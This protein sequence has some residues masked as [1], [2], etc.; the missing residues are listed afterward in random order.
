MQWMDGEA[1]FIQ[2][3]FMIPG[4]FPYVSPVCLCVT[5]MNNDNLMLCEWM[6]DWIDLYLYQTR[7]LA[8]HPSPY[9]SFCIQAG[10]PRGACPDLIQLR[11]EW[12]LVN[13]R[14]DSLSS[15]QGRAFYATLLIPDNDLKI[16]QSINQS[17]QTR[18]HS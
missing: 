2:T 11:Y 8:Y 4:R 17:H 14:Y 15:R 7:C 10:S 3:R 5:L 13:V 12:I 16:N 1:L 9:I 18:T 6:N